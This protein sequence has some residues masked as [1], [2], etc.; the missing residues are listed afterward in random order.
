MLSRTMQN[1]S[2]EIADPQ[3][4][5]WAQEQ[6]TRFHYLHRPV[7]VRCRPLAYLVKFQE[8]PIGCLIFGRPQ[9]TRCGGWYGDVSDVLAGRCPLTR[10][11]VLNL[12]RIYLCAQ[13]QQGGE[14]Y[15]PEYIPGF[16]DRC[17]LWRSTLASAVIALALDRVVLD[18]L[19][20]FPPCF[21]QEPWLLHDILSYC[22][23]QFHR[24][25]LYR[26]AGFA[27]KRAV[28]Y[29]VY[30]DSESATYAMQTWV[31]PAR[32]LSEAES[33]RVV[34]ASE[35]SSRTQHY[36]ALRRVDHWLATGVMDFEQ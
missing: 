5:R 3:G 31:R 11:Q 12:A 28:P 10:W 13:V 23:S 9:A 33:L 8:Q 36:R 6:V 15:T 30:S 19:L 1:L 32:E 22:D 35:R 4:L 25:I 29:R 7:D 21:L 17:G 14:L 34:E 18:Y 2:L 26:A 24:G 27:L 20:R 16:F